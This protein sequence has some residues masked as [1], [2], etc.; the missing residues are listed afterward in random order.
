MG[1]PTDKKFH[2]CHG[3]EVNIA[4]WKRGDEGPCAEGECMF[5]VHVE[6]RHKPKDGGE[7]RSYTPE[8]VRDQLLAH[9]WGMVAYWEKEDR[10]PDVH[11]KLSGLAHSILSTLDGCSMD[12]PGFLVAPTTDPVDEQYNRDQGNCWFPSDQPDLGCL[13]EFWHD[14]PAAYEP[15]E[16]ELFPF[17]G[18]CH[19]FIDGDFYFYTPVY[20]DFRTM[21]TPDGQVLSRE[22]VERKGPSMRVRIDSDPELRMQQNVRNANKVEPGWDRL[23]PSNQAEI[24]FWIDGFNRVYPLRTRWET[25]NIRELQRDPSKK[26]SESYAKN[27]SLGRLI[28]RHILLWTPQGYVLGDRGQA[29][30]I[31]PKRD[32]L[33]KYVYYD[34]LHNPHSPDFEGHI[35]DDERNS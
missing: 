13:H 23:E 29:M 35:D 12:L 33:K 22:G 11:Y 24:N 34:S 10:R 31:H 6:D 17:E 7:P 25:E 27:R 26:L 15:Q 21:T 9:I 8:E 3:S 18:D 32:T 1:I 2:G 4:C 20:I 28:E 19:A 16:P 30:Q 5:K 14:S